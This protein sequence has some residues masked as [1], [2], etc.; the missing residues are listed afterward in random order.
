MSRFV[1]PEFHEKDKVS[2]R[3]GIVVIFI[4]ILSITLATP[5][6]AQGV[7][8]GASDTDP[9]VSALL[10]TESTTQG[11][12]IPRM[13][14]TEIEAIAGPAEGLMAY[15]TTAD[16]LCFYDGGAW[17]GVDGDSLSYSVGSSAKGG[18]IFELD[19]TL[20]HGKV[21]ATADLNGGASY[22]WGCQG[23]DITS[24]NGA[25]S[26]TDGLSNTMAIIT[27][28]STAGIAAEACANY[29]ETVDGVLY[30]DWYLPSSSDLG[31]MY[32]QQLN[33]G[34]FDNLNYYL[35]STETDTDQNVALS[36]VTS[37]ETN[38]NKDDTNTLVFGI[39]LYEHL[40]RPIRNF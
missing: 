33:I 39:F 5:V 22:A 36:F 6:V 12:L 37:L 28:C 10:E 9:A 13:T 35:S 40:V 17:M 18:V 27:D 7:Y 4:G 34:G 19:A 3:K 30:D 29:S 16:I 14:T 25:S 24:G 21:A 2:Y 8:I 26:T 31:T 11:I 32:L 23:T 1:V 15:S 20:R 38:V